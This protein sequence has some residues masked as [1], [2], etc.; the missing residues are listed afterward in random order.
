MALGGIFAIRRP[1]CL[2]TISGDNAVN[3]GGRGVD[4]NP[5]VTNT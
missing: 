1:G 3:A 2:L 5:C 4:P